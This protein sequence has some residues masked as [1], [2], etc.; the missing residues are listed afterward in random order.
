MGLLAL[1]LTLHIVG[2][3]IWVG[4]MFFAYA[5]L[6]PTLAA[7]LEPAVRLRVWRGIFARF[8]VW[9]WWAVALIAASGLIMLVRHG[10]GSA[11]LSWHLMMTTGLVMIVL[12]VFVAKFLYPVLD[13]AVEAED[14][15]TASLVL[16]RIRQMVGVNLILGFLTI[17]IATSGNFLL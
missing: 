10:M 13:R 15:T 2:V 3:V 1:L 8:F 5:C 12:F 7:L 9:V 11:P 14:W 4:G 6:R 16:T 17:A